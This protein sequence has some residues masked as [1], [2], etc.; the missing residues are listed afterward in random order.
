MATFY[1]KHQPINT[2]GNFHQSQEISYWAKRHN[3]SIAEFQ[4][5]FNECNN[6]MS[7]TLA[8]INQSKH[9]EAPLTI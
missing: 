9:S 3:M 7:A 1:K 4:R 8:R 2:S 6:S 5:L